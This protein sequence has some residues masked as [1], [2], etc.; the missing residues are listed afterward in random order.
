MNTLHRFIRRAT[1]PAVLAASIGL[2]IGL[3]APAHADP[4]QRAG[5]SDTVNESP[6]SQN[7]N[8]SRQSPERQPQTDQRRFGNNRQSSSSNS[9]NN[10]TG[11]QFGSGSNGQQH[12]GSGSSSQYGIQTGGSQSSQ[13]Y[14]I[15]DG[16]HVQSPGGNQNGWQT[17]GIRG[18]QHYGPGGVSIPS[19]G[20][21]HTGGTQTSGFGQQTGAYTQGASN[22]SGVGKA[23]GGGG[24]RGSMTNLPGS[25]GGSAADGDHSNPNF[26][27][28]QSGA[29][30]KYDG[31]GHTVAND[32]NSNNGHPDN[33]IDANGTQ[34]K[35]GTV[36]DGT[37]ANGTKWRDGTAVGGTPKTMANS[38]GG[39]GDD[40]DIGSAQNKGPV[41][42]I[43]KNRGPHVG[44]DD[45]N[46]GRAG[47]LNG[48]SG[49]NQGRA[50]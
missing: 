21:N 42:R 32:W 1:L 30:A 23:S 17:G 44:G 50:Y 39:V 41:G 26:Q 7:P 3:P 10:A 14:G 40:P 22:Y 8:W 28:G 49:A 48:T 27:S 2:I 20:G 5:S 19:P 45:P 29:N 46:K 9:R 35:G 31:F 4:Q 43:N 6:L 36:Y 16:T 34:W 15:G 25:V 47:A 18:G 11:Q 38:V 24:H 12:Q 33:G 13:Q 37:D